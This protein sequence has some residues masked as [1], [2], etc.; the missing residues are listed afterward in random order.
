MSCFF[1]LSAKARLDDVTPNNRLVSSCQS[2]KGKTKNTLR[3]S[4]PWSLELFLNSNV[5]NNCIIQVLQFPV[6]V[7]RLGLE[8]PV[9]FPQRRTFEPISPTLASFG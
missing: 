5:G 2:L 1:V 3:T 8:K 6:V 7:R 4:E 9:G